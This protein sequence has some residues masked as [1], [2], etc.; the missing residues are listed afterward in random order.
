MRIPALY[1][2]ATVVMANILYKPALEGLELYPIEKYSLSTFPVYKCLDKTVFVIVKMVP[3]RN[4][5][6]VQNLSNE[7]DLLIIFEGHPMLPTFLRY[8]TEVQA[9]PLTYLTNFIRFKKVKRDYLDILVRNYIEGTLFDK[10]TLITNTRE[11]NILID[12]LKEAHKQGY[13]GICT[14][15]YKNYLRDNNSKL[16]LLDIGARVN[17]QLTD[18]SQFNEEV[19]RDFSNLEKK[20]N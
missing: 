11:Q 9:S 15:N 5:I 2:P 6:L 18:S 3:M 20:F 1:K 14:G 19:M 17:R 13:A 16:F 8:E 4:Q 12:L 7:R 10:D